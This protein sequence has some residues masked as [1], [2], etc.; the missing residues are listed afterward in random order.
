MKNGSMVTAQVLKGF[1]LFKGL[2]DSELSKITEFCHVH[3]ISEGDQIF[4]EGTRATDLHL[5][6]SGKVDIMIWVREP[7][8]KNVVVHR[9]ESGELFGWSALVAP[10]TYTASAECVESGEEIRIM[11]HELLVMLDEYPIVGYRIMTNLDAEISAR[12]MQTRQ[13]LSL[14]LL[15]G[16]PPP[17]STS[18]T[19]WGEP[20]KR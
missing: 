1:G 18:S 2:G 8:N 13:R 11:G 5:C 14:E 17:D 4:V 3:T 20:K 16:G 10:Y 19:L 9:V 15:A 12:L 7:W 6:H